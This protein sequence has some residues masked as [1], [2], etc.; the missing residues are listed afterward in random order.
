MQQKCIFTKRKFNKFLPPTELIYSIFIT[1]LLISLLVRKLIS[2]NMKR[3][4]PGMKEVHLFN[5]RLNWQRYYSFSP[6]SLFIT[7]GC[8]VFEKHSWTFNNRKTVAFFFI[9]VITVN[10][11]VL[12]PQYLQ[13]SITVFFNATSV[14]DG[15]NYCLP[16]LISFIF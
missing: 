15:D 5:D 12:T 4:Q 9:I 11:R 2:L 3:K 1:R 6:P 16:V 14:P 7:R 10:A 8:F 13:L